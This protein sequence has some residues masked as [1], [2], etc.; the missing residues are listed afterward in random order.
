MA[1]QRIKWNP[2]LGIVSSLALSPIVSILTE[3]ILPQLHCCGNQMYED[4][5]TSPNKEVPK[6]CCKQDKCNTEDTDA[7]YTQVCD[8]IIRNNLCQMWNCKHRTIPCN[9]Y[10]LNPLQSNFSANRILP[11][12][13]IPAILLQAQPRVY[14]AQ[15]PVHIK[16]H[17]PPRNK[18][19]TNCAIC[20]LKSVLHE[21]TRGTGSDSWAAATKP[22]TS[23][24]IGV[25][26]ENHNVQRGPT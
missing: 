18:K 10:W 3:Y 26:Q 2:V 9:Q 12:S 22:R 21:E 24:D 20:R 7:I 15:S 4:W 11:S 19:S 16:T 5:Y 14:N 8:W 6:S 23:S 17:G 13:Y 1:C 25:E